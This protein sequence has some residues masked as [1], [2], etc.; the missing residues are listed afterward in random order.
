[1]LEQK[2]EAL[3]VAIAALTAAVEANTA[4]KA[5]KTQPA[6]KPKADAGPK[7][8]AA[9]VAATATPPA[10][11]SSSSD[12]TELLKKANDLVRTLVGAQRTSEAAA[13]LGEYNAKKTSGVPVE[14]LPEAIAKLE[15]LVNGAGD[16]GEDGLI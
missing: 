16:S 7:P 10:G 15:A 12:V 14:K 3:I 13:V 1:M 11:G 8:A 2:I 5:V 6:E 9:A 4:G